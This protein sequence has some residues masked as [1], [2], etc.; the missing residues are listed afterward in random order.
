MPWE[1]RIISESGDL[2]LGT[3]QAVA[4]WVSTV[5]PGVDLQRPALPPADILA[6]F[7]EAVRAAFMRPKLEAAYEEDDFS[8]EFYCTDEPEIRC[9]HADVRGNGNPLPILARICLPRRWAVVSSADLSRVDL[10]SGAAS[11]WQNFR[12]WRD[13]AINEIGESDRAN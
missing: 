6:S 7:P 11:Q 1:I 8:I 12:D 10:T 2:P 9:L 13:G 4:D 3:K 5:L